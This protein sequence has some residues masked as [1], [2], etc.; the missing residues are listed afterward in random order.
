[1]AIRKSSQSRRGRQAERPTQI[2]W[3][4]WLDVLWRVKDN[5]GRDYIP[6]LSAGIAFYGL[7][8]TFPIIAAVIAV[9]GLLFDPSQIAQ[10]ISLISQLLPPEA[11]DIIGQRI[12]QTLENLGTSIS[13]TAAG[14]L[15]LAIYSASRGMYWL[16]QGLN[17]V[18]GEQERR[19][20]IKKIAETLALTTGAIFMT[21]IALGLIALIPII[22]SVLHMNDTL[23]MAIGLLRW[24]LLMIMVMLAVAIIYRYA[25]DRQ[26]PR[27]QWISVGS[28][29]SVTLWITGSIGFSLYVSNFASFGQVYGSLGAVV[30]LLIWFWLSAFTVLLGA[31]VNSEIEHQTKRDTTTGEREPMGER[32]AYVA[33][34][35][36][37]DKTR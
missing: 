3:A 11:T 6:V 10:Q 29:L 27:W 28:L 15:A 26:E 32:N 13:L 2:P 34:T 36:G 22:T 18:Y 35:V 4:G 1:M 8:A 17:S 12:E 20:L 16:M 25:P 33:D 5:V 19:G 23:A 24:P 21:I 37:E 9:W 31:E 14:A 7:L 30:V